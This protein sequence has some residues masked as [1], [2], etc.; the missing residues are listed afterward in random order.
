MV[1][2][3]CEP[4]LPKRRRR[5]KVRWRVSIFHW[6][7]KAKTDDLFA[8]H[9]N[10]IN[11]FC[12]K[13]SLLQAWPVCTN[14]PQAHQKPYGFIRSWSNSTDHNNFE[15]GKRSS[16]KLAIFRPIPRFITGGNKVARRTKVQIKHR[17]AGFSAASP[18]A[19]VSRELGL[20]AQLLIH[21]CFRPR[22]KYSADSID[23]NNKFYVFVCRN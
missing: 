21:I 11:F 18:C 3:I 17:L 14:A 22:R 6:S 1:S 7:W 9:K 12:P 2:V 4:D 20:S 23:G 16:H 13:R 10:L 19:K 8:C 5:F 15:T